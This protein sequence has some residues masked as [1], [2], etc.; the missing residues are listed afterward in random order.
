MSEIIEKLR[1]L[2]YELPEPPKPVAAYVPAVRMGNL[3][4][5]SGALPMLNGELKFKEEVGG[6]LNSVETGYEAAKLCA[7][8]CLSIINEYAGLDNVEQIIKVVGFVHS[9]DGFT[10]QPKVINGASDLL[11][12]VFGDR[13]KHARSAV[14][15]N[16]LPLNASVEVEMIVQ[17]R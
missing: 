11:L 4:F 5:T 2:G 9:A 13:G 17:V 3:I 15:V 12:E 16:E 6:Y 7:L 10:Q 1:Q 14:G 8:N